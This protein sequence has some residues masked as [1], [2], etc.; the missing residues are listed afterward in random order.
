[1]NKLAWIGTIA[2]GAFIAAFGLIGM[3]ADAGGSEIEPQ[4]VMFL[5]ASGTVTCLIGVIGLIGFMGWVP[6]LRT[7][8]KSYF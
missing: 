5:I 4:N 3:G 6:G 1:M 8:R 7:E 2:W